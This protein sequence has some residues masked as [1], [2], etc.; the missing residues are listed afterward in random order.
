MIVPNKFISLDQSLIA[1]LPILLSVL[2]D[3]KLVLEIYETSEHR[4]EDVGEFLLALDVL[5]VLGRIK[6]DS[7]TGTLQ[8]C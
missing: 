7:V 4:F 5:F 1:K 8:L 3:T 2:K 6:L